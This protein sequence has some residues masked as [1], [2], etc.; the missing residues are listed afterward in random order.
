MAKKTIPWTDEELDILHKNWD[1]RASVL[2]ELLPNRSRSSIMHKISRLG[3]E[4]NKQILTQLDY[5]YI[6]E[7]ISSKS[8][9]EIAKELDVSPP[10]IT[11]ALKKL[12]ITK[13][14]HWTQTSIDN[15][16]EDSPFSIRIIY[17]KTVGY[18]GNTNARDEK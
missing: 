8:Q 18:G 10:V 2:L 4:R 1:G 5:N 9:K 17:E 12:G 7:N 11:R 14:N 6:A 13:S 16:V 3:Y 15:E